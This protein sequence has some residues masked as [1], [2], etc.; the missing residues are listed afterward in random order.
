[1][2]PRTVLENNEVGVEAS[3]NIRDSETFRSEGMLGLVADFRIRSEG[4]R[5]INFAGGRSRSQPVE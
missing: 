2:I 3:V 4:M 5:G 1:V